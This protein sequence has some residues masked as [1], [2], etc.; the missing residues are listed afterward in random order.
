MNTLST[1][2]V[3]GLMAN[4]PVTL[5]MMTMREANSGATTRSTDQNSA[6]KPDLGFLTHLAYGTALAVA[7][8]FTEKRL[9]SNPM[10]KGGVLGLGVYGLSRLGLIPSLKL[11]PA[12]ANIGLSTRSQ[13]A[14]AH[15]IWGAS[16]S[17]AVSS[18]KDS[19][20]G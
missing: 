3:A 11:P 19:T 8:A 7:Y 4:G 17:Q 14:L 12:G 15:I 5:G 1:G 13:E 20:K 9:N 16:I 6:T 2:V 18:L 10:I